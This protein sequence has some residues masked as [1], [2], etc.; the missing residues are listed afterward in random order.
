MNKIGVK[1]SNWVF[2]I[3]INFFVVIFFSYSTYK[4]IFDSNYLIENNVSCN[5]KNNIDEVGIFG[6][7]INLHNFE[8]DKY[9]IDIISKK[10]VFIN[11]KNL[12]N[13]YCARC[14]IRSNSFLLGYFNSSFFSIDI[15]NR[16]IFSL[17]EI[18]GFYSNFNIHGKDFFYYID[19]KELA[20]FGGFSLNSNK[21]KLNAAKANILIK[22]KKILLTGGVCCKFEL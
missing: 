10:A 18:E 17:Q 13:F 4:I 1:K 6:K 3:L 5:N 14:N 7:N 15:Q 12:V 21:Q 2:I 9:L 19:R 8:F 20:V 22:E 11:R 16:I